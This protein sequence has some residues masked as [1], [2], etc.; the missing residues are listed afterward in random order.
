MTAILLGYAFLHRQCDLSGSESGRLGV[1]PE[2][3]RTITQAGPGYWLVTGILL[4]LRHWRA[5]GTHRPNLKVTM[6]QSNF[7]V[8]LPFNDRPEIR[9]RH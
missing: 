6:Y 5:R 7:R 3:K 9:L 2:P 1:Q 8:K 4:R